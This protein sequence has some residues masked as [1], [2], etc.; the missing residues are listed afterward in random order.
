MLDDI[1]KMMLKTIYGFG[2]ENIKF[3][4]RN[5]IPPHR[6]S[7]GLQIIFSNIP[8][9][10]FYRRLN[11]LRKD[12][13]IIIEKKKRLSRNYEIINGERIAISSRYSQGREVQLTEKGREIVSEI[14]LNE[15]PRKIDVYINRERRKMLFV[16]AVEYLRTHFRVEVHTAFFHL[17]S[18]IEK[19]EFPVDL[20]KLGKEIL[21]K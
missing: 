12:G 2:I 14:L 15:F 17:L 7:S 18:H 1:S 5:R 6:S 11:S 10:T 16:D 3:P 13:Y 9:T 4:G 21:K 20:E 8:K 19:K